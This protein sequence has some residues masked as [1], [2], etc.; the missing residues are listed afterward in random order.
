M[1][2]KFYFLVIVVNVLV[3]LFEIFYVVDE[4]FFIETL[5]IA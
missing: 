3:F 2:W 5:I 1:L 4:Y